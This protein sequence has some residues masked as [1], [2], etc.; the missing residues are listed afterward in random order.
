MQAPRRLELLAPAEAFERELTGRLK[1]G[2]A[3]RA[4]HRIGAHREQVVPHESL[5]RIEGRCLLPTG[6]G[7]YLLDVLGR[8][9]GTEHRE[10]TEQGLLDRLEQPKAPPQRQPKGRAHTCSTSSA[11]AGSQN[12][13]KR[14][15]RACST[16]SSS[17]WLHSRVSQRVR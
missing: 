9:G 5:D 12:T 3:R 16:G 11:V 17:P 7:A 10:A 15:N 1:H 8:R 13:A 14:R 6:A 2:K 4:C